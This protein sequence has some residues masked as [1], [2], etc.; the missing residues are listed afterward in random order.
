MRTVVAIDAGGTSTRAVLVTSDGTCLGLGRAGAG[1][2]TSS[3]PDHAV[4]NQVA[5]TA[6]AIETAPAGTPPPDLAL[7]S[8]AGVSSWAVPLAREPFARLGIPRL[9]ATGD[10]QSAYFSGTARPDGHVLIVGTG[11]IC[12][13]MRAGA[14]VRV[15]DGIGYLLGDE[16]SG[17]WI[18][19][20]VARAAA[21]DLDGRGPRTALTDAVAA[22]LTPQD[23]D[24]A[25][26]RDPRLSALVTRTYAGRAAE[27]AGYARIALALPDD[28]VAQGIVAAAAQ[29]V[30]DL[31]VS[32][33]E[34][35]DADD[36]PVV[37][38]GGLLFDGSPLARPL[39]ERWPG[40]CRRAEDGLAGAALIALRL[41]GTEGAD[42][43]ALLRRIRTSIDAVR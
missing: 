36:G 37:L 23:A 5:A 22:T 13:R 16:G 17:F 7:L 39:H 9:E 31:A 18:G 12:G 8:A 30:R 21:A 20:A 28:P 6:A 14:L 38:A 3:G 42:E 33:V 15:R 26:V 19:Q 2:P 41:L 32:L 27:L 34:G 1:N 10:V 40:R 24:P 43:D 25:D 35:E 11:A 29:R 4:A